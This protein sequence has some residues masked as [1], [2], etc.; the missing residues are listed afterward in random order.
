MFHYKKGSI[1]F[2]ADMLS[3]ALTSCVERESSPPPVSSP[4]ASPDSPADGLH[5]HQCLLHD[6][7]ILA[8]GLLVHPEIDEQG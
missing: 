7:P 6:G 3:R 2:I 4:A 1:N 8:D 5:I